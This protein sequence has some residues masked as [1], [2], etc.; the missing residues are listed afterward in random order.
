MPDARDIGILEWFHLNDRD[1]VAATLDKL[2]AMNIRRLRTGVS[3]A[4]WLRPDG[5]A[6]YEWLLPTLAER[7]DVLP[8]FSYTPP[9]RGAFPGT[10]AP[11]KRLEDFADFVAYQIELFGDHFDWVELWN[12]PDNHREWNAAFDPHYEKFAEMVGNA[13]DWSRRFGK[14]TLLGG[15]A[16]ADPN[17]LSLMCDHGALQHFD[18]VGVHGFP[19]SFEFYWEGWTTRI[20]RLRER[21]TYCGS[22]AQIW[23]TETGYST[24]RY[25]EQPQLAHWVDA[26]EAPAERVYW[27]SLQDLDPN[28]PTV[29]GFH[30]DEREYHFG[31]QT[32]TG[33][34]KLLGRLWREKGVAELPRWHEFTKRKPPVTKEKVDLVIGGAGF[35]GV[36]VAD[37]ICRDGG[38]VLLYDNLSRPGVEANAEWLLDKHGDRVELLVADVLDPHSLRIAM[39]RAKRVFHYAAQVAVTTSLEDPTHDFDVNA[40]GTFN[41]LEACR[42]AG[43][44]PLI[45]TSTNKVYGGLEDVK[46]KLDEDRHIPADARYAAHG[47]GESRNLDFHSP[48]GCSKGAADQYVIDYARCMGVPAVVFRMSCIYG[49]HQFGTEDQ[50]WVA[51]FARAALAGKP[52]TLYGDGKQVRDVLFVEDLA[53]AMVLA[54]E[55]MDDLAGQAFNIGG[56]PANAVS[57]LEVLGHLSDATGEPIETNFG[58]WRCGDQRWY[59][60]DTRR[61]TAAVGWRPRTPPPVGLRRLLEWQR[62]H[63]PTRRPAA[64]ATIA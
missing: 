33:R 19:F 25:D 5:R 8:C 60:S 59:V 17:F 22:T 34:E 23:I 32:A 10:N 29:D 46:L 40:R 35:I 58:D 63:L 4:D 12:E 61:F 45:F 42:N 37:R 57:L 43:G 14:K 56:G 39:K 55:R 26:A 47:V 6:W 30:S 49:P 51:H 15:L 44:V 7:V 11:P 38:R 9:N 3:W 64:A 53:E 54:H 2:D 48:Y 13:A 36:N 41:V 20:E 24:W 28:R 18:A 52:V 16:N 31:V 27:Y 50:G 21:L 62:E 1:H